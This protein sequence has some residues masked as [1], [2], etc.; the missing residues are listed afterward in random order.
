[1]NGL[2]L[3]TTALLLSALVGLMG[4]SQGIPEKQTEKES[5]EGPSSKPHVNQAK[6]ELN[7]L[8]ELVPDL[9]PITLPKTGKLA[10]TVDQSLTI[11]DLRDKEIDSHPPTMKR[12]WVKYHKNQSVDGLPDE[13]AFE[14]KGIGPFRFKHFNCEFNYGGWH[15]YE[16][17][18]YAATHG[19]NIIYPYIRST[20][21]VVHFPEGTQ[22]LNWG[23]F[24]NWHQWLPEHKIDR[25]RY[26]LLVGKDLVRMHLDELR[27]HRKRHLEQARYQADL[28]MIDQEHHVLPPEKLREQGWYPTDA[29]VRSAFERKYYDGYAQTYISSIEAARKSGWK[30]ISIYGWY[31][32]GRT[33]GGLEKAQADPGTDQAWNA[34]GRQILEH[35]DTVNNSVYCFYWSPQNVAYVL[36]NIDMNMKMVASAETPKPVRPY[37]WTLLHG[38]GDD[39]RWWREQPLATEETRAMTAMAFFTGVDGLVLWNWSGTSSHHQPALR[40]RLRK[41]KEVEGKK[42]AVYEWRLHD[43][44]VGKPFATK[45][46]DKED[47]Q[48]KRYDA[49]HVLTYDEDAASVSFQKIRPLEKDMGVSDEHPAFEIALKDLKPLLR[50][51]SEP[52]ASMVEGMALVKPLEYILRHGEVKIDVPAHEQF[53]GVLP[54]VR[55]VKLNRWHIII[56]YDPKVIFGGEPRS[57]VLE[58]FDGCEGRSLELPA[59]AETR[60]FI[61]EE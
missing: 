11:E 5:A 43:V 24:I 45:V 36:A 46:P 56:T 41:T 15:N 12:R 39:W 30:S 32:Y 47:E 50:R 57:I 44:M 26:D 61:L 17:Q 3:F 37:F 23:G 9:E 34:F 18:D 7:R 33:W 27:F 51:K 22:L 49:L 35:V 8:K 2:R 20:A 21:E 38:G 31:P 54:I 6:E 40:T 42:K 19:F 1:M 25:D 29:D 28:L 13:W 48:F 60:I 53:G 55:R 52:V 16:M 10:L 4:C 14:A 58:D 59:D